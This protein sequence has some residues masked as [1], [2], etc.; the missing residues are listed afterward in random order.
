[1][2]VGRHRRRG[3]P[4]RRV[5]SRA[6]VVAWHKATAASR[7]LAAAFTVVGTLALSG[8]LYGED[9]YNL[10]DASATPDV[11]STDAATPDSGGDSAAD[12][13]PQLRLPGGC[14]IDDV[15]IDADPPLPGAQARLV[16]VRT[17]TV[18]VPEPA[19]DA[20][21]NPDAAV[22]GHAESRLVI[23]DVDLANGPRIT[24]NVQRLVEPDAWIDQLISQFRTS[25]IVSPTF[26][27]RVVV[28]S[29]RPALDEN[30]QF[31]IGYIGDELRVP[32]TVT[33]C[34]G[35]RLGGG[36][37][38]GVDPAATGGSAVLRC[39]TD[40]SSEPTLT[41]LLAAYCDN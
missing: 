19:S 31:V 14:S 38:I 5:R 23:K 10:P 9:D 3:S 28:S 33:A 18:R 21:P 25:G 40:R 4:I 8:C 30:A 37:L 35:S 41:P 12:L 32:F 24:G 17:Q 7:T 13:K 26:G 39:G 11:E 20:E 34:D 27:G 1:M 36:E 2:P 22:R 16:A 29:F 15:R 6:L